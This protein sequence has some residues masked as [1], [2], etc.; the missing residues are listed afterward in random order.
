MDPIL[1]RA[2]STYNQEGTNRLEF[3]TFLLKTFSGRLCLLSWNKNPLKKLRILN[4]NERHLT[5][6][7]FLLILTGLIPCRASPGKTKFE[8]YKL[9]FLRN[10]FL[11][12]LTGLIPRRANPDKTRFEKHNLGFLTNSNKEAWSVDWRLVIMHLQLL[13]LFPVRKKHNKMNAIWQL[14]KRRRHK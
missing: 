2:T 14:P 13:L 8:K 10:S 7:L 12:V 1:R 11:P 9:G 6:F 3:D 5:K 4:G